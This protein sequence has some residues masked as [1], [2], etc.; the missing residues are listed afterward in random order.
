M[1]TQGWSPD[2][3]EKTIEDFT[4][5]IAENKLSKYRRYAELRQSGTDPEVRFIS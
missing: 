3:P 1:Q 2:A 5:E 4:V